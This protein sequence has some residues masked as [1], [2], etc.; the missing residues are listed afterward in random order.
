MRLESLKTG[1]RNF[2]RFQTDTLAYKQM[3][4]RVAKVCQMSSI[5]TARLTRSKGSSSHDL[6]GQAVF[7]T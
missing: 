2:R 7:G 4:G 3:S 1:L 5:I 6:F